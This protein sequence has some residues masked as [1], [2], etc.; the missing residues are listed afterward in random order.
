M[1]SSISQKSLKEAKMNKYQVMVE[2]GSVTVCGDRKTPRCVL[3]KKAKKTGGEDFQPADYTY[4]GNGE[5]MVREKDVKIGKPIEVQTSREAVRKVALL[6][7]MSQTN[8][9]AVKVPK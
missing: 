9:F 7:R 4:I 3:R 1:E 2:G 6:E 8:L 5:W